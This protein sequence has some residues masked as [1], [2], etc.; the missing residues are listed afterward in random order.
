MIRASN[1]LPP[2]LRRGEIMWMLIAGFP[3]EKWMLRLLL[4]K[5]EFSKSSDETSSS[6]AVFL[7]DM[8]PDPGP[9]VSETSDQMIRFP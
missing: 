3:D 2:E 4:Q 6:A 7:V 8:Y 5:K 1:V 9:L